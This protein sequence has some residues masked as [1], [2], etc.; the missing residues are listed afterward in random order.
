MGDA[1]CYTRKMNGRPSPPGDV[2]RSTGDV[3]PGF[4]VFAKA[5][6]QTFAAVE[7]TELKAD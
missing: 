5:R 7:R 1:G 4:E 2:D 6:S 3:K